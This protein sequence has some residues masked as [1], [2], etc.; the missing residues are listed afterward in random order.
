MS[1]VIHASQGYVE[2]TARTI[3]QYEAKKIAAEIIAGA[4]ENYD[5]LKEIADYIA[6]DSVSAAELKNKV[7]LLDET[8]AEKTYVDNSL[9]L[10]ADKTALKEEVSR[11]EREELL[12]KRNLE[13]ETERAITVEHRIQEVVQTSHDEA[14]RIASYARNTANEAF[15]EATSISGTAAEAKRIASAAE[16]IARDASDAVGSLMGDIVVA[17]NT[18]NKAHTKAVLLEGEVLEAKAAAEQSKDIA[19]S[20][21]KLIEDVRS[22]ASNAE[23]AAAEAKEV[24][25]EAMGVAS[26]AKVIADGAIDTAERALDDSASA[27]TKAIT[28]MEGLA[29]I[30][31]EF[32]DIRMQASD[33]K[34]LAEQA[35]ITATEAKE[36][37]NS[38]YS[39]D[40]PPPTPDME[41]YAKKSGVVKLYMAEDEPYADNDLGDLGTSSPRELLSFIATVDVEDEEGNLVRSADNVS[42]TVGADGFIIEREWANPSDASATYG[43]YSQLDAGHLEVS[44]IFYD[45]YYWM[46]AEEYFSVFNGEIL[47]DGKSGIVLGFETLNGEVSSAS[48]MSSTTLYVN[49]ICG[50]L[51]EPTEANNM[52]G[53]GGVQS[54]EFDINNE[55][56]CEDSISGTYY[57]ASIQAITTVAGDYYDGWLYNLSY[58]EFQPYGS[59]EIHFYEYDEEYAQYNDRSIYLQ[60]VY[61]AIYGGIGGS[62]CFGDNYHDMNSE[63]GSAAFSIIDS[64]NNAICAYF[65]SYGMEANDESGNHLSV[66][67]HMISTTGYLE[68][69]MGLQIGDYLLDAE[70]LQKLLAL[71]AE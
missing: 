17:Q 50:G 19:N 20:A 60:D 48:A 43:V 28:A 46:D 45:D 14:M 51:T 58:I 36:M 9:A 26:E 66:M 21:K 5:T 16:E 31:G 59:N 68:T 42:G 65:G 37:A 39:P 2:K 13:K 4:G 23:E 22:I 10:K 11:A 41:E 47:P 53:Y 63:Y 54:I 71:I 6:S 67:P 8:K 3:A 69:S 15:R 55:L 40:N 1:E 56:F 27:K 12:I 64:D 62:I 29:N 49:G 33:A 24:V 38:A 70:K 32:S 30:S 34:E 25:T 61:N 18:A 7:M 35:N 57:G 44:R 52:R